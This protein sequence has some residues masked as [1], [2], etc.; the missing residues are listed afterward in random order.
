MRKRHL[1]HLIGVIYRGFRNYKKAFIVLVLLGFL[2]GFLEAIGVSALIP[3]FTFVLHDTPNEI[4]ILTNITQGVFDFLAIDFSIKSLL[5]LISLLFVIKSVIILLFQYTHV[6][7][8]ADYEW[9]ERRGLL[10][11]MLAAQWSFLSKQKIGY[12]DQVIIQDITYATY[13]LRDVGRVILQLTNLLIYAV[14]AMMISPTITLITLITGIIFFFGFKPLFQKTSKT[15]RKFANDNKQVA[16]FINQT[17]VGIKSIKTQATLSRVLNRGQQ[18][19]DLLKESRVRLY[20]YAGLGSAFAQP[21]VIIFLLLIFAAS[22]K[23]SSFNFGVFTVTIYLIHKMFNYIEGAQK[24]IQTISEFIPYLESSINYLATAEQYQE[25]AAGDQPFVFEKTLEFRHVYFNYN[26]HESVIEDMHFTINKGEAIGIIGPSGSG[27]TTTIDLLLRLLKP[28]SGIILIDGHAIDTI[29]IHEWRR[30]IGYVPQDVFLFNDTIK[31]NIRFFDDT[32]NDAEI[33]HAATLSHIDEFLIQKSDWL[34]T[35]VGERGV[36]LSTGQRQ[37][38]VLARALVRKPE[39]LI[40][41]E[42]TSALDHES[43]ESIHRAIKK[44]KRKMTIIIIAH[45]PSILADVDRVFTVSHGRVIGT[46]TPEDL[47]KNP[48]SFFSRM[49]ST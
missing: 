40:L 45:R 18:L 25:T 10:K 8:I 35:N 28:T 13:V 24:K 3:L 47:K 49:Q 30:K 27:K 9:R 42:A 4:N 29:N 17:L 6:K 26:N 11:K 39:V 21:I 46:G 19:F 2:G 7:I 41:D 36:S 1:P 22:Y 5:V 23:L 44:L 31:E 38:I 33:L 43:E 16:H 34:D 32:I 37:R 48:S 15:A 20:F 14:A 12:L